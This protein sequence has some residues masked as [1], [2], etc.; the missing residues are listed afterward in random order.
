MGA[1]RGLRQGDPVSPTIFNIL[2][3]AEL[4]EVLLEV[5]DP[6][7]AHHG[8]GW[9]LGGHNIVFYA[10]KDQAGFNPIWVQMALITMVR[11][12]ERVLLLTNIGKIKQMLC[13]PTLFWG[14]QGTAVYNSNV[15]AYS[16]IGGSANVKNV[17]TNY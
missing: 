1:Q 8:F 10:D 4:R 6:Q 9:A 11:M 2:V 16:A 17:V 5:C 7:E 14:Q 12:F 13:T 15:K 3:I